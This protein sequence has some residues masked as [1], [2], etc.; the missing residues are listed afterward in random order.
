MRE[1]IGS[2]VNE[3]N[4]P[5]HAFAEHK[6]SYLIVS[7]T[8][9]SIFAMHGNTLGYC[10]A[11]HKNRYLTDGPYAITF[12]EGEWMFD[13]VWYKM[14]TIDD[15][16]MEEVPLVLECELSRKDYGGLKVDFDKLL[17]AGGSTKVFVTTQHFLDQKTAYIQNA[18]NN[19]KGF[20][21]HEVFYLII[22]D[23]NTDKFILKE[24][25]RTN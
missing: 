15:Q 14:S 20:G 21:M 6:T 22:W 11:A 7:E 4:D 9:K 23:E 24:F 8:I 5:K 19:F 10:S 12:D 1:I 13:F 2:I 3:L 18:L 25:S 16:I 17:V